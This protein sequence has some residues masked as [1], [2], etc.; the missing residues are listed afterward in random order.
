MDSLTGRY[1]L[2]YEP[3]NS[4]HEYLQ[5]SIKMSISDEASIHDML[6]FFDSFVRAAGFVFEGQVSI[7]KDHDTDETEFW[8]DQ[9]Y[10]LLSEE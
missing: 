4:Q 6:D 3:S 9:T 5:T 7:V 2:S 8:K 10:K 1:I